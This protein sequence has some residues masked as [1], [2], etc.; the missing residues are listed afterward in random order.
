MENKY[1]PIKRLIEL[2]EDYENETE[3]TDLQDFASWMINNLKDSRESNTEQDILPNRNRINNQEIED[4]LLLIKSME[5]PL[6]FLEYISR[7]ARLHE[8]Y[9]KKFFV[10]LPINNRLEYIFL[11]TVNLKSRIKKTGLINMHMVDYTTGMDTIKRL[12]N[13]GYLG[14]VSDETDKRVKLLIITDEGKKLLD[15][16]VKKINEEVQM[17][18]ACINDNK[19]KK[20]IPL[21]EGINDFH[22]SFYQVHGDKT[23]AELVNLMDSLKRLYK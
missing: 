11:Y 21:L 19:W 6:R 18:L 23:P 20:T 7:V 12:V 14:E 22:S 8:F 1:Q 17:F 4:N 5:E 15:Q 13:S 10:S 2:W 9:I 3:H 16:A